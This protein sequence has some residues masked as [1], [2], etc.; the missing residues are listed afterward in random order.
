MEKRNIFIGGAWPY[1]NYY[2]H[3]GHLAALLPGDILAKYYRGNGD[4]VIYVS[5][6]DCHGTPITER[7]RKENISPEEIATHYHEEFV[8]TFNNLGFEYDEYSS[9]MTEHHK[10][11]VQEQFKRMLDN[12]Y[13]YEKEELQ[14]YCEKC[15][16]FL[17]DREI[18]GKCPHCGGKSTGDQ[19]EICGDS[20]DSSEVLDKHCKTCGTKTIM[21]KN[22]HL[23]FKLP[24]FQKELQELID[25]NRTKWRK[26]ALGE[27]QKYIDMGLV[28]RAATRQLDWGVPVPVPGYEDKRIY[29]WIEAVLGYLSVGAEVAE[30]RNINFDE[31]MSKD[32]PNTKS[33]YIHGK[34]N[35]PFHT[36]IYPALILAIK[37]N[38]NL[39]DYIISSAYV[40]L[41]NEKM[42]KSKGNL[43][44]ANELLEMFDSDTIRFYFSFK[45]PETNDMNCSLS[46][47]IQTHNKFLVGILGNFVNRNLSFINKKFEGK[48]TEATIDENI[49]E[50]T[51]KKYKEVGEYFEKGE[52]RNAVNQIFEYIS[53]ANKYYDSN[54][55]WIQVK[56]DIDSFNNTTYTCVYMMANIANLIAPILPHASIKI[57]DMLNLKEYKWEEE[58]IKGDYQINN[59]QVL[60]DRIDEKILND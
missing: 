49:I 8:K 10:T 44:T 16:A 9:T 48:I 28:D 1:A 45:G 33:Y 55:P 50:E 60:Y 29:V 37:N 18:V 58:I 38:Y 25:N 11:Y 54:Q 21:K 20:L 39:P 41:D 17:S 6:S 40:N 23:Y 19:C 42:S 30:K 15:N 31:Y 14:D 7:A 2:L 53:L 12:G 51:K 34:D 27:A 59:L 3:V 52:I 43:I 46:D 22:K 32:N 56:E 35:I 26:N 36:T 47:I 5:G 24:V 4:N 57:K 13:V